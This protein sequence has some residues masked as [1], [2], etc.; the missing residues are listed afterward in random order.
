MGEIIKAAS[1]NRSARTGGKES[2]PAAP[3]DMVETLPEVVRMASAVKEAAIDLAVDMAERIVLTT[4]ETD[5]DVLKKIYANALA[6]ARGLERATI[7]VHPLDREGSPID[8]LADERGFEVVADSS[9]GRAGCRITAHGLEV[10]ASLD[11]LLDAFRQALKSS[12][13]VPT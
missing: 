7:R 2:A 10:D 13:H 12:A 4:V 5:P 6:S 8:D 11:T 3:T 9:V 1:V